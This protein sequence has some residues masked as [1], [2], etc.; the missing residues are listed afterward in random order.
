MTGTHCCR[1]VMWRSTG[2]PARWRC[3]QEARRAG[4]VCPGGACCVATS[5]AHTRARQTASRNLSRQ[6]RALLH[7]CALRFWTCGQ[8]Q[9]SLQECVL[10][11][12][13]SRQGQRSLQ[14][15]VLGT[16]ASRQGQRSLQECV[17][18]TLAS[19]QGQLSLQECSQ[20]RTYMSNQI[21]H[22]STQ[23]VPYTI[24]PPMSYL[25]SSTSTVTSGQVPTCDSAHSW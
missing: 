3:E 4:A 13:A 25:S 10:G 17:L 24:D 8:G 1:S 19:R 23:H 12:L 6:D 20:K 18:G 11:T 9:G 22:F 21:S 14:E 15:C 5:P 16:L 7:E 2:C